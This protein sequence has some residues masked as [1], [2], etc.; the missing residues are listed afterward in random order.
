MIESL[1]E[2]IVSSEI[3]E[4]RS[5]F[6]ERLSLELEERIEMNCWTNLCTILMGQQ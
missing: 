5:E 4:V 2:K 3:S 6:E 1:N